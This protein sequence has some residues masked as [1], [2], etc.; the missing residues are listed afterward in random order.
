MGWNVFTSTGSKKSS[1]SG[2][3]SHAVRAVR[4]TA[5][6]IP[7]AAWT[8]IAF[9]AVDDY[10]FGAMHDPSTNNTRLTASASGVYQV[11]ALVPWDTSTSGDRLGRI[12]KN[13]SEHVAYVGQ[14]TTSNSGVTPSTFVSTQVFLSAGD[15]IEVEVYQETGASLDTGVFGYQSDHYFAMS[16]TNTAIIGGVTPPLVTH[17]ATMPVSPNNGDIW[18][19]TADATAGTTWQFMY[20]ASSA[21]SYKWEF[22]GGSPRHEYIATLEASATTSW[23]DLATVGPSVTVPFDGDY[24]SDARAEVR[25][26]LTS[27]LH[28]VYLGVAIGAGTPVESHCASIYDGGGGSSEYGGPIAVEYRHDGL[29][30]SDE[31]RVRYRN[32]DAATSSWRGRTLSVIP[33]RV[34]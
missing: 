12:V 4:S 30:A 10:D 9:N 31:L 6:A 13:G 29:S 16:L 26:T 17:S 23:F 33:V 8:A 5:Q 32:A 18:L 19:Y 24:I 1:V 2:A 14:T 15:Y 20:N 34:G 11:E 22:I 28:R 7:H 3:T 27:T 25:N 21:S